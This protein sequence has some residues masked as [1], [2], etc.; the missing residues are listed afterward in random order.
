MT[1]EQILKIPARVLSQQQREDY[2]RTDTF[3]LSDLLE[4]SG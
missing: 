4:M 3:F 2:S 1:P